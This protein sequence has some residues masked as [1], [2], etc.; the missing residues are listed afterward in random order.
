MYHC[1]TARLPFI[2]EQGHPLKAF[3]RPTR[4]LLHQHRRRYPWKIQFHL[5]QF[6]LISPVRW[7]RGYRYHR[8][9]GTYW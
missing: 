5:V 1:L 4:L 9:L 6:H 8:H 3:H 7:F 2:P